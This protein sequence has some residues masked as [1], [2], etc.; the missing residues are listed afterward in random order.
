MKKPLGRFSKGPMR[1]EGDHPFRAVSMALAGTVGTGNIAGITTA[2]TLGRTG[3]TVL[4]VGDS[5]DWYGHQK[6][7][8]VLLAVKFRERNKYGDWVGGPMYYI[9]NGLGEELEMAGHHLLCFCC[10][11]CAG[12]GQCHSG[13]QYCGFHSH[14]SSGV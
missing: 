11:G 14:S 1:G 4:A 6:Y 9:K 3:Y 8:E 12:H 2:V 5:P 7:S 10:T 13:G